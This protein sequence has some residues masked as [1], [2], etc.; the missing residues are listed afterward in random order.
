MYVPKKRKIKPNK[1][2]SEKN[3]SYVIKMFHIKLKYTACNKS[4]FFRKVNDLDVLEAINSLKNTN[5]S[6]D[7]NVTP[8]I[9]KYCNSS[10]WT[11]IKYLINIIFDTEKFSNNLKNLV[12]V[13]INKSGVKIY[14]RP[15]T[16]TSSLTKVVEKCIKKRL[17]EFLDLNKIISNLQFG[18][19]LVLNFWQCF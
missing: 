8:D 6:G 5:S 14:N 12:V 13:P 1:I 17:T 16:V 10:L 9:P 4:L 2:S 19:L 15:I 18:F 3:N 11:P 7:D